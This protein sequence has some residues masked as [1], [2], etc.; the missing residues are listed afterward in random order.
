MYN[1]SFYN[2]VILLMCT[3]FPLHLLK[4]ILYTQYLSFIASQNILVARLTYILRLCKLQ[5]QEAQSVQRHLSCYNFV[6]NI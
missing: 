2:K 3:S 5:S 6:K 1:V 4:K